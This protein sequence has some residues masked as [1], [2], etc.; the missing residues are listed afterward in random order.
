MR[1]LASK[2]ATTWFLAGLDVAQF[3]K[4][5]FESVNTVQLT[6]TATGTNNAALT[7]LITTSYFLQ[8]PKATS[9]SC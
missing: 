3:L 1:G 2:S 4:F 7:W 9:T 6:Y 5:H 8:A